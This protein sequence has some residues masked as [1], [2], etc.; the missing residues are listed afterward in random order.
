MREHKD[1]LMRI[2]VYDALSESERREVD[3]HVQ[4]CPTCRERLLTYQR[5]DSSLRRLPDVPPPRALRAAFVER[6]HRREKKGLRSVFTLA[7]QGMALVTTAVLLVVLVGVALRSGPLASLGKRPTVSSGAP[8]TPTAAVER[9][10][11]TPSASEGLTSPVFSIG[12]GGC[13]RPWNWDKEERLN[14]QIT[15][16]QAQRTDAGWQLTL[17][18]TYET[19][20]PFVLYIVAPTKPRQLFDINLQKAHRVALSP[21]RGR[22]SV[23]IAVPETAETPPGVTLYI[24][25]PRQD[26]GLLCPLPVQALTMYNLTRGQDL[27]ALAWEKIPVRFNMDACYMTSFPWTWEALPT[28]ALKVTEVGIAPAGK[29]GNWVL[30]VRGYYRGTEVEDG[31]ERLNVIDAEGHPLLLLWSRRTEHP[32]VRDGSSTMEEFEEYYL[33]GNDVPSRVSLVLSSPQGQR[34]FWQIVCPIALDR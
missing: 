26:E 28:L 20:Q 13:W 2:A 18:G 16:V 11:T 6:V 21:R 3:E 14:L 32:N 1:M 34:T 27:R 12:S 15:R 17:D 8:S 24:Y 7:G 22:F 19:Q 4:T 31:R 25:S 29:G 23:Q 33:L 5:M 10:A 9:T 30:R